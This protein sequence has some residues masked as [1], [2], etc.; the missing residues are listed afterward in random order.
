M[1]RFFADTS[2][3]IAMIVPNDVA[4]EQ[5]LA[6]AEEPL[7][8]VTTAWVMTE[9]AAY[10]SAPPNRPLFNTLLASLRV[11]PAVNFIPATQEAFDRGAELYA[12]R[13]DK[14]WSLVDC[15]SFNI[16]RH[17]GL[18]DALTTD[19]HFTQAGFNALLANAGKP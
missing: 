10:L 8:L 19:H 14:A 17:E 2:Y 11:H 16:M 12:T 3:F 9:L 18:T 15:I 5:A 1:K 7:C 6:C 13:A 4:H